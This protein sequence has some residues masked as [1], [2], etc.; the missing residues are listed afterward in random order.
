[1]N[2]TP[3]ATVH[4]PFKEKF[5]IPR[6]SVLIR[7]A[8]ALLTFNPPYDNPAAFTGLEGFSHLWL[9]FG[10]HKNIRDQFKPS[11]RPPRLGGNQ[12]IG[13]FSTRSSFRPNSLGLSLVE[14]QAIKIDNGSVSLVISCPDLLDGTPIYDIKP[15][16]EYSDRPAHPS[17]GFADAAPEP[18]LDVAF[19]SEAEDVIRNHPR[20]DECK[21][22]DRFIEE[23]IK[24]DPRPAY[25][26]ANKERTYRMRIFD[27]E[28]E[29][30][31]EQKTA[32]IIKVSKVS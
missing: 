15:Y 6:Q 12:S 9:Q 29:W 20:L 21:Q 18:V 25:H 13:V 1:M 30:Q 23:L 11:V 22:L 17:C 19:A 16:V 3:I 7:Y 4:T 27:L 5:G 32:H 28:I 24:Q 31:V 26:Q 8:E 2:I 10:F 14:L